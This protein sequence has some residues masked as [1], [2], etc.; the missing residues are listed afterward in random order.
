VRGQAE[1]RLLE[2]DGE[3]DGL[4][5]VSEAAVTRVARA[6]RPVEQASRQAFEAASDEVAR[7]MGW[8]V[9]NLLQGRAHAEVLIRLEADN[10][11]VDALDALRA[12]LASMDSVQRVFRRSFSRKTAFFDLILRKDLADFDRQWTPARS[13][14]WRFVRVPDAA[15][16]LRRV[17]AE[18][19]P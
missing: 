19:A 17:R 12:K 7:Y 13:D 10:V 5:L 8:H 18:R 2:A 3:S 14:G 4:E 16:D 1:V 9:A 11:D 15:A 6:G